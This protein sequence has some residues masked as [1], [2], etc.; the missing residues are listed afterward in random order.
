MPKGFNLREHLQ[1][2]FDQ[3]QDQACESL[4][5]IDSCAQDLHSS[6]KEFRSEMSDLEEARQRLAETS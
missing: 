5:L 2:T 4:D 1:E 3:L 6:V